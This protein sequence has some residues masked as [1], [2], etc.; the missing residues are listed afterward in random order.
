MNEIVDELRVG[1]PDRDIEL[2][3]AVTGTVRCDPVRIG[4]LVSNLVGNAIVHGAADKPIRLNVTSDGET[5]T[6]WV[7]NGGDPIPA[8]A[9]ERLFQPFFRSQVRKDQQGLGLGLYIAS[10]IARAHG[11]QIDVASTADE[12]RFT[13]RIPID[14]AGGDAQASQPGRSDRLPTP[15]R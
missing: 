5:F 14:A 15:A 6:L 7:A 4:Q 13:A 12:T 11:G 9:M 10:E 3:C 2:E 8:A 1:A